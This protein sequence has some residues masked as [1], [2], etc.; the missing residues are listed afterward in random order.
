MSSMRISCSIEVDQNLI[1]SLIDASEFSS[2]AAGGKE[3]R[4]KWRKRSSL[5]PLGLLGLTLGSCR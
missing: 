4:W 1:R 3:E 5:I 2:K